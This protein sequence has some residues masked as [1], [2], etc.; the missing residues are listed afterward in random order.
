[1]NKAV[2]DIETGGFS[3]TKNGICEIGLI[4]LN[5]NGMA[6]HMESLLIRPYNRPGE[7]KL[8]SYKEDAMAV[9]GL[10]EEQIERDGHEV[11]N[12]CE[13]I[14]QML[15]KHNV[16]TFIGHNIKAFDAPRLNHLFE[17]FGNP[18]L[19]INFDN[20][21]DTLELAK[22]QYPNFEAHNLPYLCKKFNIV[23]HSEHRALGDCKA[24]AQLYEILT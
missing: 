1:M 7:D 23:N 18:E 17:R 24:T 22:K 4:I 10:T 14:Q 16:E 20:N 6:V 19:P 12:V 21:I 9:N 2:I 8:V 15:I 5:K 11:R 3:I 13:S